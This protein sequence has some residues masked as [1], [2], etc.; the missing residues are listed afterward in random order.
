MPPRIG[1]PSKRRRHFIKEW[2]EFRGFTQQQLADLL[3]TTKTSISRIEDRKTGYTQ[4]F[5]EACGD[6]LGAHPATLLSRSPN[7]HDFQDGRN[8]P[9]ENNK[10]VTGHG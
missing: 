1:D 4:D 2:R 10:G 6:A 3:H 9:G 8:V 5:L 7:Q